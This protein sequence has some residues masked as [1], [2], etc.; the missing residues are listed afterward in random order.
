MSSELTGRKVFAIVAGGF[1]IVIAANM[2]MVYFSMQTFPGLVV[3][4]SYVASQSFDRRV[5]AQNALG[6][7]ATARVEN[8]EIIVSLTDS[9]GAAIA[10]QTFE[11]EIGRPTLAASSIDLERERLTG[12]FKARH[13]LDPGLWQLDIIA[14]AADGTAYET[15]FDL[16]VPEAE[17]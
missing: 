8:G 6:W 9:S 11:A 2:T 5:K 1:G 7:I 15:H 3:K 17:K 16:L 4:N 14:E 12:L 13:D 10:P